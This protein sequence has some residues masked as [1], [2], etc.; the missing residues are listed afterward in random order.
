MSSTPGA[1]TA[2]SGNVQKGR[3]EVLT[4]VYEVKKREGRESSKLTAS[5]LAEFPKPSISSEH[6][7]S[8]KLS[9]DK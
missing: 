6:R 7:F 8:F 9:K 4:L 5:L 2:L 3:A 1:T